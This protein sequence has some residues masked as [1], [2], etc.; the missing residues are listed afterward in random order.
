VTQA[1]PLRRKRAFDF[2]GDGMCEVITEDGKS[3]R[4]KDARCREF[5]KRRNGRKPRRKR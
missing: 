4:P 2:Y 3:I 1:S 5:R